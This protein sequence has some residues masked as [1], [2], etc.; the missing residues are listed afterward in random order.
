MLVLPPDV[1]SSQRRHMM[2][3]FQQI[4]DNLLDVKP[5]TD[6]RMR[7]DNEDLIS[8]HRRHKHRQQSQI[9]EHLERDNWVES[10]QGDG[11]GKWWT[12]F[13]S[14]RSLRHVS[15]SSTLIFISNWIIFAATYRL[16]MQSDIN[17]FPFM[18]RWTCLTTFHE[19]RSSTVLFN[20]RRATGGFFFV[21][22][23]GNWNRK[24]RS[25]TLWCCFI[26]DKLKL[27]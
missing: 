24:H 25:S 18:S 5:V 20:R 19:N 12:T 16:M 22:L 17:F 7:S 21:A 9:F 1:V 8:L 23:A 4:L 3:V 2:A 14:T 11:A 6:K 26:G 13:F 15:R 27:R 10:F